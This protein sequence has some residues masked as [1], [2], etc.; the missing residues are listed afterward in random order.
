M[1]QAMNT[2]HSGSLATCHA[3][4]AIDTLHRLESMVLRAISNWPMTAV[5]SYVASAIDIVIH[6]E[7]STDGIRR[8]A[9]VVRVDGTL[10]SDG[11]YVTCSLLDD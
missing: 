11:R 8:I 4:S 10:G 9:D 7:R 5:R 2:G 1:L 3:N 6:V